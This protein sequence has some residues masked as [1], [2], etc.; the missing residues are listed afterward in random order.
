MKISNDR[1]TAWKI[2]SLKYELNAFDA[3]T[4][5]RVSHSRVYVDSFA[6]SRKA[7]KNTREKER[8]VVVVVVVVIS[9]VYTSVWSL[10]NATQATLFQR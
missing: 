8:V 6:R 4:G 9:L 3:F 5:S 7:G 10:E 2:L 1:G